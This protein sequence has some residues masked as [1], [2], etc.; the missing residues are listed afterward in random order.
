MEEATED[1]LQAA[2]MERASLE[3]TEEATQRV[4][5]MGMVEEEHPAVT[6]HAAAGIAE[7]D[8]ALA[9]TQRGFC[10]MLVPGETTSR[11]QRTRTLAKVQGIS[12]WSRQRPISGRTSAHASFP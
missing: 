3:A 6:T 7:T 9:T 5:D 12:R 1:P 2:V 8:A 4:D 10:L 11:T